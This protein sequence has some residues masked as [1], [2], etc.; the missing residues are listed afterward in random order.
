MNT[1]L[2]D[3]WNL[4]WKLDFAVR[5][6]G[7]EALLDSYATE[8][9]PVIK[10]VIE[11]T[12]FM[13]RALGTPSQLAQILRNTFIPM[14]S[15]LAP[16]QHGFVQRLSQL[17][18]AYGGSP[19]VEGPGERFFDSSLRG[20]KGIGSRFLL[21]VG[22]PMDSATQE[23]ARQLCETLGEIVELRMARNGGIALVR[24]DGYIAYS[25]DGR[26][27]VSA[28]ASLRSVLTRQIN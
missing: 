25:A 10:S 28:V 8:R 1:G 24:P 27:G 3:I 23:A 18:I 17:G 15:R 26:D 2:Q 11:T 4:V 19:I 22:E 20:G 12:H 9:L 16:F 7:T 5:G 14:V 21:I 13:T 6:H